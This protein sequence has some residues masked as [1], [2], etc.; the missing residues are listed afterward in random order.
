MGRYGLLSFA[1][2][3]AVGTASAAADPG[4]KAGTYTID[5]THTYGHFEVDHMGLSTVHGRVDVKNGTIRIDP[6][7]S[8]S[9]VKVA[10]DPASVDTGNEARDAHLRD[11]EDFFDVRKYPT[12]TFESTRVRF[13]EDDASEATVRGKLTLHG[14]TRPVTLDVDDIACRDNPLEKS[15]YTCGFSAETTLKRSDFGMTAYLPLVGDQIE[16][17]IDAEA[18]RP[19]AASS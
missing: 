14:V 18:S 15:H 11:M 10:L 17:T 12:M 7:G 5:P 6:G 13:D 9:H 1:L 16:L 4:L 2:I 8:D 19:V 3:A